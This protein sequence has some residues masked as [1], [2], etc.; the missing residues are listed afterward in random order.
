M[1]LINHLNK[2]EDASQNKVRVSHKNSLVQTEIQFDLTK[3]IL[4]SYIRE[5]GYLLFNQK[6]INQIIS[7]KKYNCSFKSFVLFSL[8]LFFYW[9]KKIS[10]LLSHILK[11]PIF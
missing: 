6:Q 11:F 3:P 5:F 7:E 2:T 9:L 1:Y 10:S 4:L 8:K